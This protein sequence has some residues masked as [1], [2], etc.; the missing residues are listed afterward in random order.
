MRLYQAHHSNR[1]GRTDPSRGKTVFLTW[2]LSLLF[3]FSFWSEGIA[4]TRK[5]VGTKS[6]QFLKLGACARSAAMADAYSAVTDD[7]ESIYWNPAGL[8][9]IERRSFSLMHTFYFQDISYDFASY[10]H[11]IGQNWVMG[12]GFQY[13]TPGNIERTDRLGSK[14]GTYSPHDFAVMIG[15]S[16]TYE[17]EEHLYS[18]GISGKFIQS[19]VVETGVAGAIDMGLVWSPLEKYDFSLSLYNIGSRIKYKNESDS[20][21]FK[22][23]LGSAYKISSKWLVAMDLSFP[24]DSPIDASLGA[25][26]KKSFSH[27]FTYSLRSGV[28]TKNTE[29]IPG[30]SSLSAGAGVGWKRYSLD[31]SWKPFGILGNTY[32]LSLSGKF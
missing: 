25:E 5:S 22:L 31:I 17:N 6:C 3:V 10:A 11:R 12:T 4:F 32:R 27:N 15:G 26:F 7:S 24:N 9:R 18:L 1:A 30:F 28:T 8:A 19:K 23:V 2:I 20:L 14:I 13:L 29:D 21:P 16:R